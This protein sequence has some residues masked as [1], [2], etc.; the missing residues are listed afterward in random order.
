MNAIIAVTAA[1]L[2]PAGLLGAAL[3]AGGA[4][5]VAFTE[6][7]N[8]AMSGFGDTAKSTFN[9]IA[10]A[11]KAGDIGKAASILWAGIKGIWADG[12]FAVKTIWATLMYAMRS[13]MAKIGDF[14]VKIWE[15]IK[16]FFN[17]VVGSLVEKFEKIR[18]FLTESV[19]PSEYIAEIKAKEELAK[20]GIIAG[21]ANKA[22]T[23]SELAEQQ[24]EADIAAARRERDQAKAEG[25][26]KAEKDA[27][28]SL[29]KIEEKKRQDEKA[30]DA[31]AAAPSLELPKLAFEPAVA[32]IAQ[33]SAEV[34]GGFRLTQFAG[35][36]YGKS[37]GQQQL[38]EAKRSNRLLN[39]IEENTS[40]GGLTFG[41]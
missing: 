31:A 32:T 4:A 28:E 21:D 6:N 3:L 35:I 12:V 38:D 36:G 23:F 30:K 15:G 41:D 18:D 17:A 13:S 19:G 39:E 8:E 2:T 26:F 1:L 7:G 20:Q 16:S 29:A 34:F 37:V 14:F 40:G 25:I 9:G 27:V 11:L 22:P 24:Y 33:K 10:A 5:I